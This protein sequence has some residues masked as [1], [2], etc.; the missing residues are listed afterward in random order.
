MLFKSLVYVVLFHW[1]MNCLTCLYLLPGD[2]ID[3]QDGAKGFFIFSTRGTSCEHPRDYVYMPW[4]YSPW[5][6]AANT[7]DVTPL[8]LLLLA[9]LGVHLAVQYGG[10]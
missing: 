4:G 10:T 6:S 5:I 7:A 8:V 2:R 9:A 3:I 1:M